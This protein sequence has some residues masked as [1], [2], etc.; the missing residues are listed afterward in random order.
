LIHASNGLE[1]LQILRGEHPSLTVEHP[2]LI[3]L[4]LNMPIMNGV[5]FLEAIR[6]DECIDI[7]I[8][9]VFVLTTSDHHS[10][11]LAAYK[12]QVA[13]YIL[14]QDVGDAC[15]GLAELIQRYGDV[16]VAPD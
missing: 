10:D 6:T 7:D 4:D 9:I 3:F 16:V 11:L 15:A 13:G 8:G 12:S 5:E 1:A 2:Y 14:K